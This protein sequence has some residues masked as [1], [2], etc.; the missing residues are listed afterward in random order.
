MP[1]AHRTKGAGRTE[2]WQVQGSV[3]EHKNGYG[4]LQTY[5]CGVGGRGPHPA[6]GDLSRILNTHFR[7]RND[8]EFSVASFHPVFQQFVRQ[9]PCQNTYTR[10]NNLSHTQKNR[11]AK[12]PA[13]EQPILC[14][15]TFR[16]L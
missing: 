3:Q 14:S 7:D 4:A 8:L 9:T 1:D 10:E 6:V 11:Q 13:R 15:L 16:Y 5:E 2:V 12:L